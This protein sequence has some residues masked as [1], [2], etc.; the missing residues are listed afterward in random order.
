[1]RRFRPSMIWCAVWSFSLNLEQTVRM[2]W[3]WLLW[4]MWRW[5]SDTAWIRGRVGWEWCTEMKSCSSSV[6]RWNVWRRT[7]THWRTG[8]LANR[9]WPTG[10]TSPKLGRFT[11]QYVINNFLLTLTSVRKSSSLSSFKSALKAHLS[12]DCTFTVLCLEL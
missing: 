8:N 11:V 10:Q 4:V 5:Y 6:R 9:W 2:R 1:M 3:R 7:T 12:F